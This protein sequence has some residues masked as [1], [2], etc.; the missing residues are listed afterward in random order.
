MALLVVAQAR[1]HAVGDGVEQVVDARPCGEVDLAQC[2]RGQAFG[3]EMLGFLEQLH[4][5]TLVQLVMDLAQVADRGRLV[6]VRFRH[7]AFGGLLHFGDIGDQH[8]VVGGHRA[9]AFGDDARRGQRVLGAGFGQWLHDVAGVGVQPV[10]DRAEAA[11]TGAFIVHAQAAAD[12]DMADLGAQPRQLDEVAGGLAHAVGDIAHVGDLAAHVEVQQVQAVGV[13]G[14]AQ[15]LPQVQQLARRQ[16]ELGLVTAAVLPLARTQRGQTHA[17]ADAGFH[18]QRLGLLQHQFQLGGLLDD[19]VGL[20]AELAADQCQTDVFAVLVAVADDQPTRPAQ[21]Q[22]RHQFRLGT[23]FQT[24]TLAVMAGQGAGHAAMLV[25][26]DRID[27]GVAARIVPVRLRLRE[28]GL[29]LA[30]TLA[31]DVRKAHQQRQLG[32]GGARRIDDLR[33]RNHRALRACGAHHHMPGGIDVEVPVGPV[34]N[35]I[36]L[37]G[38]VQGPSTAGSHGFSLFLA[39]GDAFFIAVAGTPVR[40]GRAF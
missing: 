18:V 9:A 15:A 22:H 4:R 27:R 32:T 39:R 7:A 2:I 8:R 38:L 28:R 36:G 19:D 23:G 14:V 16:P 40:R 31:E 26:L 5:R 12:V 13:F 37:A 21:R 20:Q 24:E 33:Q 17:H 11:R 29:Q 30:Q 3:V 35:R 10:V 1:T 25:D 6:V 34:R